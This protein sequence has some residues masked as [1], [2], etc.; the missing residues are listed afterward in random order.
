MLITE[1]QTIP[2]PKETRHKDYSR[3]NTTQKYR[4]Y[5]GLKKQD[6]KTIVEKT[7]HRSTDNT[8]A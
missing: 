4:Q 6:T 5:H 3:K 2:W 1:V 7:L 8:M